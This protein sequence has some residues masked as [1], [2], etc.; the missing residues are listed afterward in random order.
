MAAPNLTE[1]E[2]QIRLWIKRNKKEDSRLEFKR[3]IDLSTADAKAEFIRDVIA[4]ANSEGEYPRK[5]GHLVVGVKDGRYHDIQN[6][7]YDG[8][9]FGQL[10]DSC[11]FPAI[12]TGYEEFGNNIRSRFGVLIIKPDANTL[13]VVNNRLQNDKGQ[14]LLSPGQSWGRRSDRKIAL[15]GADIHARLRDIQDRRTDDATGPLQARIVKLESESGPAFEAKR[16]RFEMEENSDWASLE[17]G[18]QK[19][20]PYAREFDH[21]V[22][23]QVLDAIREATART[24]QGMPVAVA[25]SVDALLIEAMPLKGG[26]LQ[27]PARQDITPEDQELLKRM[28]HLTFEMTWDASRYLRDIQVLEIGAHLYWVLIRYATLNGLEKLKTESLH[29][30]RYCRDIYAWKSEAGKHF[31]RVRRNCGKRSTMLFMRFRMTTL[32]ESF[33]LGT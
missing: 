2:S 20:L 22:K 3:R 32:L 4:L 21:T 7:H 27:Y 14:L 15:S 24:R 13:Y 18:L 28:E 33:P 16:I 25:R 29:N 6:E 5:N 12:D 19:L 9:T 31:R 1:L 26:G 17:A 11:V 8:A 10:L 23:H 30:A